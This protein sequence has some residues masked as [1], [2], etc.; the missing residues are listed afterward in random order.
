MRK[1]GFLLA[2]CVLFTFFQSCGQ[3]NVKGKA[4]V[5][6]EGVNS[7]PL[8]DYRVRQAIDYAIDMDTI[9]ETLLEGKAIVANS[10]VPNG[11]W[12]APGLNDY[13]YNP[14]K[15]K[16]LLK[17]AGWD[18]N[19]TLDVVFYY[20]DQLTVDIMTAI[21]A[22]LGAVGI[23]MDFRKLEGD[24]GEQLWTKPEDPVNGPSYVKWDMAYAGSAA[25]AMHEYYGKL[26]TGGPGNSHTPGNEELDKLIAAT[27]ASADVK[28]QQ[29]AFF[30]LE[31]YVNKYLPVI[32]L[33]YQQVFIYESK[34]MSRNGGEY[35]NAQYNYDWNILNW[36]VP[37]DDSG[38]H[39]LY[40]NTAP[41][42]FFEH[43]WFNPGF[44]MT[45]KVVFDRLVLADGSL[46]PSRG[47]L[48][49]S[50][51]MSPDGMSI[52]F[53]LNDGITWHDGSDLTPE[54]I[55]WSVEYAL[56]VPA[57]HSV[58]S[59]TFKSLKGAQDF[60]DGKTE[61]ISGIVIDGNKITFNFEKLDPNMMLTFTQFPPLPKKYF[62][63]S[64]PLQFQQNSFWQKPV[65]SGPFKLDKVQMNDYTV[66][67]PYE[68]YYGG[69]AKLDEIVM[70]PSGESDANVIKNASSGKLDYGYTKSV[71][72]VIALEGMEHMRVTPVDIPYTRLFYVNKFPKP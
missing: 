55:K 14:E 15:A 64:D 34:R 22:Y 72:D 58:F 49:S 11:P 5:K 54:D 12:K 37:A 45:N 42:E 56:K 71:A 51:D 20:G 16:E 50:Y 24:L 19:Y 69:K 7:N 10:M 32:P 4:E 65:G 23:K 47:Q 66:A 53:T 41:V 46:M 52:T 43:P 18:S 1:I 67:V 39:V 36:T 3:Q 8:S 33:Y 70:Y 68:G 35:G 29:E 25:L 13:K 9:V 44:L 38:K 40:T 59:T 17:E 31:K 21:Q 28:K 62:E 26:P 60:I 57:I 48:A 61:G 6:V 27:K 63:G 30:A 2:V